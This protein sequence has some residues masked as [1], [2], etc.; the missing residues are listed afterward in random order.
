MDPIGIIS[1]YYDSNT[2]AFRVLTAHGGDVS[3][4]ALHIASLHPEMNLD[5]GFIHEAAMLHDI[6]VFLCY[7]PVIGCHGHEEYVCHGCL[8]A[9]L[10]RKEG[11]PLHA[12]VC[13]RHTGAGISREEIIARG[14]PLPHVDMLP[15]TLEERLI[16]FADKFFSKTHPGVEKTVDRIAE[17]L[18]KFG[19][20]QLSRFRGMCE[21]FLGE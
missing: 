1:K 17:S 9:A 15:V 14:L 5:L 8:G 10:V 13:E 6:G 4:K 3:R 18:S 19:D 11:Y 16:C 21:L 7:A 20:S 12:L 2:Q